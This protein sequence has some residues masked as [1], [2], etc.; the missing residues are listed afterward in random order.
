[1]VSVR[2]PDTPGDREVAA[3]RAQAAGAR[4]ATAMN[5]TVAARAGAELRRDRIAARLVARQARHQQHIAESR[6]ERSRH[7]AADDLREA[8]GDALADE[9]HLSPEEQVERNARHTERADRAQERGAP[10]GIV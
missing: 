3:N 10:P 6:D 8:V 4:L 1:M 9:R 2:R 7:E 5:G